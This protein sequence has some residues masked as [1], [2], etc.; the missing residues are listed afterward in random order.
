[1]VDYY[2]ADSYEYD[3]SGLGEVCVS[4]D[5]SVAEIKEVEEV[6]QAVKTAS[7]FPICLNTFPLS[8]SYLNITIRHRR[9][10]PSICV[11]LG[12]DYS[13]GFGE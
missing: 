6:N 7:I 2:V 5:V 3:G 8:I 9:I 1:M 10:S 13:E 12:H 4:T 11:T